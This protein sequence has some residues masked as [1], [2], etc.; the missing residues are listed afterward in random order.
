MLLLSA[1]GNSL[2]G[3]YKGLLS[4][5]STQSFSVKVDNLETTEIFMTFGA[6][7]LIGMS[8]A[9]APLGMALELIY[10]RS[11]G[12]KNQLRVNG[13]STW[14]YYGSFFFVLSLLMIL[15]LAMLI[16]VIAAFQVELL[17]IPS[18]AIILCSLYLLYI[19]PSLIFVG[20]LSFMFN[21]MESGQNIYMFS[22][23]N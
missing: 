4:P 23:Y 11:V 17:L 18:A 5:L 9:L 10:D 1:L 12:L 16:I 21:T 13:L 2:S 19:L 14:L 15:L 20:C 22:R 8:Y 7:L 3:S 6:C